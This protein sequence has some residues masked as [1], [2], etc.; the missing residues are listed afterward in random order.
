MSKFVVG[1]IIKEPGC[2]TVSVEVN[3]PDT[4]GKIAVRSIAYP[5]RLYLVPEDKYKLVKMRPT[6]PLADR[7]ADLVDKV[8]DLEI[9]MAAHAVKISTLQQDNQQRIA[10]I[11]ETA[12]R[13]D[14]HMFR[15]DNLENF[16][17]RFISW[18]TKGAENV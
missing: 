16:K 2:E 11:N 3:V 12:V 8:T 14:S 10:D 18:I 1:D 9:G 13:M 17:S 7:V 6:G 4:E 15:L 5:Q